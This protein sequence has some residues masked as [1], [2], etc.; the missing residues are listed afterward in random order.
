L[1]APRRVR[2]MVTMVEFS[3]SVQTGLDPAQKERGFYVPFV[4]TER[5]SGVLF[6]VA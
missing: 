5:P 2:R 3:R 1:R 4:S 6:S